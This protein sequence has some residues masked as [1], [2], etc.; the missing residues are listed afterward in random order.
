M[1]VAHPTP[2]REHLLHST[3]LIEV[4]EGHAFD[5]GKIVLFLLENDDI[6]KFLCLKV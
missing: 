5:G 4:G 3:L 1:W 6:R 2:P